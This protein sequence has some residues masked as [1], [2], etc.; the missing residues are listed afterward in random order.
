MGSIVYTEGTGIPHRSFEDAFLTHKQ[1]SE[2]WYATGYL[3]DEA[4]NRFSFQ[5][6]LA[7]IRIL[8]IQFHM[9]LTAVT[10]L[11]TGRHYYAQHQSFFGK[12]ITSNLQETSFGN[13]ASIRYTPNTVSTFGDMELS[14]HATEYDLQ[15]SMQAK[16]P[17]VWH[18]ADGTLQM[19]VLD[20]PNQITYYYS[21]T[22]LSANGVL[23]LDGKE[24]RV[25]G[26][27][28]FDRQGGPCRLT[29]PLTNWE[30][31]SFRFFDEEEIMLFSFPRT[32]YRDGTYIRSDGSRQRL[33]E[34]EIEPLGYV[35]DTA[36]GYRFSNGWRVTMTSGKA[37]EYLVQPV[38][39]GQLNLFFFELLADVI[40]PGGNHVGYCVVELLPGA[41]NKRIKPWLALK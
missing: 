27:A 26:K 40:D 11:Q 5:Y 29:N 7:Q 20:D 16:K 6:T 24:H 32:G 31:F 35:T 9:L 15:L 14:M 3:A 18:C 2:W 33:N 22:N 37:K 19:G 28:W 21:L 12:G 41:R 17:P 23:H 4:G 25:S 36:T 8:G 13:L 10:D 1:C 39:E 34:Y 38:S 30:W